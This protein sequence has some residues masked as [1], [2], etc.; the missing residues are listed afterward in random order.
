[1]QRKRARLLQEQ[2]RLL[3]EWIGGK[4]FRFNFI[5]FHD[6]IWLMAALPLV[7]RL[8]CFRTGNSVFLLSS[9][10]AIIW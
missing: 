5:L 8:V 2:A 6:F 4:K 3:D 10:D 9:F 7:G 1:M